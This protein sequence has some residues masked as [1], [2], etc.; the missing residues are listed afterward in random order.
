MILHTDQG[1]QSISGDFVNLCK[2][3]NITHNMIKFGYPYDNTPIERFYNT[4]KSNIYNVTLFTN[5]EMMYELTMKYINWYNYVCHYSYN[6][7]LTPI[8][9]SYR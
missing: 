9:A 6:N 5:V 8:D 7:Y 1:V 2:D 3:N 4:F